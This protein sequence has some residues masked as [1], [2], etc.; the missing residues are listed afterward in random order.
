MHAALKSLV[1]LSG[2]CFALCAHGQST[3]I[4]FQNLNFESANIPPGTPQ[5]SI[6]PAANAFPSWTMTPFA[7]YD[8]FSTGGS[9]ISIFDSQYP[10]GVVPLQG[11][12]SAFLF[13][14]PDG[15]T[16]LSQTGLVPSFAKSMDVDLARSGIPLLVV[17]MNGQTISLI[18]IATFPAYTE[19]AGDISAFADQEVLLS[20]TQMPPSGTPP[21]IVE[22]DDIN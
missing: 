10:F 8:F 5:N 4:F 13:G 20:F 3:P 12:Y 7:G 21:S 11:N 14:A 1:R 19:Y 18:P 9:I 22:L 2:L 16:V 15:P 6:I 17:A